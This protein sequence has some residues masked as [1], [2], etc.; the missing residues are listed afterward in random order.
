M[1]PLMKEGDILVIDPNAPI[2]EALGKV[3]LYNAEWPV[4]ANGQELD[5]PVAHRAVARDKGGL[6]MSGDANRRTETKY[7]VTEQN[8]LGTVESIHRVTP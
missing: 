3:L 6:L 2:S 8:Y 7:R 4:I 5:V 1:E